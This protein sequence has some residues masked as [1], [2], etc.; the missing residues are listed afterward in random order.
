MTPRSN[1]R[2]GVGTQ[3]VNLERSE[4]LI[5]TASMLWSPITRGELFNLLI[6]M[7][8]NYNELL[9]DTKTAPITK[10]EGLE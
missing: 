5:A 8:E 9:E 10:K 4:M 1:S 6:Y 3:D 7:V 2:A